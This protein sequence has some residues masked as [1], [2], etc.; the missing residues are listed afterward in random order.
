MA[1]EWT[2][3][4]IIAT[5]GGYQTAC[6]LF[7]A[8]DLD[9]FS[10]LAAKPMTAHA[11]AA[12]LGTDHRATVIELDALAAMELL[13]KRSAK[14]GVP[15]TVAELL[16]APGNRVW[17]TCR[18]FTEYSRRGCRPSRLHRRHEQLLQFHSG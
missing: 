12:K 14:Y 17:K 11:L 3:E 2:T 10:I 8:A 13:T 1:K 18:R 16:T 5:T 9:I 6:V 15:R 7:A 4:E